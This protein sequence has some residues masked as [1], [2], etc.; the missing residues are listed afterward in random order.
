MTRVKKDI[1]DL[2]YSVPPNADYAVDATDI[3]AEDI[4]R[5]RVQGVIELLGHSE[6]SI[7]FAAAR[8][9]TSWGYREGLFYLSNALCRADDIGEFEIHRLYGYDETFKLALAALVGYFTRSSDRGHGEEARREIFEPIKKI[10]QLSNSRPFEISGFF[11]LVEDKKFYEY[12]PELREHLV[13]VID[14]PDIHRWK[15]YDVLRLLLRVDNAFASNFLEKINKQLDDFKL[16][17]K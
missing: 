16:G 12:I 14:S 8:L 7:R 10:I 6:E 13:S 3:D 11:W 5:S 1:K 4:P 9:L 2:L 17:G 15:I